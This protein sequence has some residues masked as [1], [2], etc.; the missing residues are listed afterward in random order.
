MTLTPNRPSSR[1]R[2]VVRQYKDTARRGIL[3]DVGHLSLLL[4]GQDAR[5]QLFDLRFRDPILSM[6]PEY[7]LG[8]ML[9]DRESAYENAVSG[10]VSYLEE[11]LPISHPH[12]S[13]IPWMARELGRLDKEV[14]RSAK[15][16]RPI[17]GEDWEEKADFYNEAT[18]ADYHEAVSSLAKK[19]PVIGM[20]AEAEDIDLGRVDLAQALATVED[21]EVEYDPVTVPQ[22]IVV[23]EFDDGYT[24]QSLV[25]DQ[26]LATEGN[27]MG[28][29]V[30]GYSS[31]VHRGDAMIFSLR[32]PAGKPHV[33]IEW[34]PAEGGSAIGR[35]LQLDP[36]ALL[37]PKL[38]SLY[39]LKSKG[40]F[41]QIRGKQN[42]MPAERYRP[43]VQ[44]F[45]KKY[46]DGNPLA[47]LMVA[48]PGQEISFDGA[49]ISKVDFG[50]D[51]ARDGVPM[52]QAN[53]DGA[54]FEFCHFGCDTAD[55]GDTAD[56]DGTSFSDVEFIECDL[57][58]DMANCNFDSS[59]FQKCTISG[60]LVSCAFVGCTF[61]LTNFDCSFVL[62]DL[63]GAT[64]DA[65]DINMDV[66][67][68]KMVTASM[69]DST[70][71]RLFAQRVDFAGMKIEN[72]QWPTGDHRRAEKGGPRVSLMDS[73]LSRVGTKTA[74]VLFEA[75]YGDDNDGYFWNGA[76]VKVGGKDKGGNTWP[77]GFADELRDVEPYG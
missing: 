27:I 12:E 51:W 19:A 39:E 33:T 60:S 74:L 29:C 40:Q 14:N 49:V 69:E 36:M 56:W 67:D 48:M 65:C 43:Y 59:D 4:T 23:M 37:E 24:I 55:W 22:G 7:G 1:F 26:Q 2:H 5:A 62:C 54:R 16:Y 47:L 21:Y 71:E 15:K 32:N 72:P 38:E 63:T 35:D 18:P 34:R 70:I 61:D 75:M 13:V 25:D 6:L 66:A 41:E 30:G 76:S 50:A 17:A 77:P 11:Y 28:H 20:W 3:G 46:F 42:E 44:D 8:E 68:S 73:D 53:W 31:D 57:S 64:F 52:S 45:I 9:A 10:M 58:V